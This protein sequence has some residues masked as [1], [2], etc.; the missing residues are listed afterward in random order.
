M[1]CLLEVTHLKKQI[2]N[3]KIDDINFSLYKGK[4]LGFLGE[5][6]AGKTT[7]IKMI[8][9]AIDKS[10][11]EI[12]IFG[13]DHQKEE[14]AIKKRLGYVPAEDYL[15]E[16]STLIQH[17]DAIKLFYDNWDNELFNALCKVWRL[18]LKQQMYKYSTGM[19]TKA[20]LTLALAHRPDILI[21][22]EPTAGL[23]PVARIEVLDILKQFVQNG[24]RAVF[25]STHIIS[26][27]E[28]IA[29]DIIIL[30]NGRLIENIPITEID[31][32]Y[33][34]V[35]G[36][37]AELKEKDIHF[38]GINKWA[39]GFE[40]VMLR[41][42]AEALFSEKNLYAV[43]IEKLLIYSIWRKKDEASEAIIRSL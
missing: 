33:A 37:L 17:A 9:N 7:T 32:K 19:K 24:E 26:D 23:D 6:G 21:L 4:I 16:R 40:G 35:Q 27:L 25:F 20:M 2:R 39:S 15:I 42:K 41:D 29:D 13:M 38:I 22:D 28:K 8:L 30:H 5:N 3:F 36:S 11:G 31:N 18:P 43:S 10:S 1:E 12:K 14:I 34:L